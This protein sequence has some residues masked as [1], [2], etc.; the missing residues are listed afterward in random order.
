MGAGGAHLHPAVQAFLGMPVILEAGD[1][2][3]IHHKLLRTDVQSLLG[4]PI[5]SQGWGQLPNTHLLFAPQN[6]MQSRGF[7]GPTGAIGIRDTSTPNCLL[8]KLGPDDTNLSSYPCSS[9]HSSAPHLF[10]LL[11]PSSSWL[12]SFCLAPLTVGQEDRWTRNRD[13]GL[14]HTHSWLARETTLAVMA[15]G[16]FC[17]ME[18]RMM[19]VRKR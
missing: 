1:G 19:S 12:A 9:C 5:V 6:R 10:P 11:S 4:E 2:Q 7:P 18:S 3:Q 8:A 14:S 16:S 15:L 17:L 13:W